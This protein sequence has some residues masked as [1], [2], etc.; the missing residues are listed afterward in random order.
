MQVN[1]DKYPTN[2]IGSIGPNRKLDMKVVA[3]YVLTKDFQIETDKN[4]GYHRGV[5]PLLELMQAEHPSVP[6]VLSSGSASNSQPW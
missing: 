1:L 6:I 2:F 3:P 5:I 4:L